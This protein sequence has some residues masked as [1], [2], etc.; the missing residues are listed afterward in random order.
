MSDMFRMMHQRE[1]HLLTNF[2]KKD[3]KIYR[4][5]V[6]VYDDPDL[7][8]KRTYREFNFYFG[9]WDYSPDYVNRS[10]FWRLFDELKKLEEIMNNG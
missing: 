10:P 2:N 7:E 1:P 4:K 8:V 6:A 9:L 3:L 5:A